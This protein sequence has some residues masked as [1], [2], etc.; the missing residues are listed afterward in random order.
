MKRWTYPGMLSFSLKQIFVYNDKFSIMRAS[1]C[2]ADADL[3]VAVWSHC[4]SAGSGIKAILKTHWMVH[5]TCQN[6]AQNVPVEDCCTL[7]CETL[8]LCYVIELNP[9][10]PFLTCF[11]FIFIAPKSIFLL[12]YHSSKF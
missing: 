1:E 3:I 4:H 8:R 10:K 12:L 2:N 7:A 6:V 9:C 5:F 11:C